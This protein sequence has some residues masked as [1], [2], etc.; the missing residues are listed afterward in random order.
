MKST[1]KVLLCVCVLFVIY[2]TLPVIVASGKD[3]YYIYTGKCVDKYYKADTL[4]VSENNIEIKLRTSDSCIVLS[5]TDDDTWSATWDG[6]Q[7]LFVPR[8]IPQEQGEYIVWA[9]RQRPD[10]SIMYTEICLREE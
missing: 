4:S 6:E 3:V 1:T 7:I 2:Y 9:V 5:R 8:Y 10:E